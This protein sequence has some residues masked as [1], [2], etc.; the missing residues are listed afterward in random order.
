MVKISTR[1]IFQGLVSLVILLHV[2][3]SQATTIT[4]KTDRQDVGLNES[5]VMIFESDGSVDDDPDFS[6][7][8]KDFQILSRSSS[9]NM[10]IVNGKIS[11]T[12]TWKLTALARR[13]GKLVIPSIS[14]GKDRSQPSFVNVKTGRGSISKPGS[15]E[16]IFLEVEV[17]EPSPYVQAEVIYTV[18]LFLSVAVSNASLTEV[19][20][21]DADAIVE[22]IDEDKRYQVRRAGKRYEVIERR[23]AIYPLAS[24]RVSIEPVTFQGQTSRSAFS[25]FDPFGPEPRTIVERS[26]RLSLDV[27][28]VPGSFP[29]QNWLP[30]KLLLLNETW[31][32]EPPVFQ[33]G[34]PITRT[35]TL[36]AKGQ[37][38]SQLPVLDEWQVPGFKLYP[39]QPVMNDEKKADGTTAT[40]QEKTAIIPEQAGRY[41]LPAIKIPWWN[42]EKDRLEYAEL[43]AREVEVQAAAGSSS[44]PGQQAEVTAPQLD[45]LQV[46][47]PAETGSAPGP[48]MQV[49]DGGI[50]RGLSAGLALAW[51]LT[52]FLWWKQSRASSPREEDNERGL[53]LRTVL[54]E[55]KAACAGNNPGAS[56]QALLAWARLN[57]GQDAPASLGGIAGHCPAPLAA[58]IAKLNDSLYSRDGGDW[59]GD[60]L[61]KLFSEYLDAGK[62]SNTEHAGE[63]KPLYKIQH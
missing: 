54:S 61:W 59:Q 17:N 40:R 62:D 44:V 46:E 41:T 36:N 32:K 45:P 21:L 7:L 50:W 35:L 60:A 24:G 47:E 31:S 13:E 12:K 55:L 28:P 11:S 9:S 18:R 10:S 30:A 16:D 14:F 19:P 27:R 52:L 49:T 26:E 39:D 3:L 29:G 2:Q 38:A 58:E 42:T 51:L 1:T 34:E 63:L 6:P 22:R 25:I 33:A 56:K 8:Q 20:Q 48:E 53:K 4:V 43:P 23:Y 37:V 5:F 15:G 57:W